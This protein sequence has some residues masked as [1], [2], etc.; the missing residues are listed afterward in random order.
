M[1]LLAMQLME[2][3]LNLALKNALWIASGRRGLHGQ[4]APTRVLQ[5][6]GLV[7]EKEQGQA[8]LIHQPIM[9]LFATQLM[10]QELNLAV[11]NALST[12]TGKPGTIGLIVRRKIQG[13][14]AGQATVRQ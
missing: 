12:V 9:E 11:K 5:R 3:E 13:P 6:M 4:A 14:V 2:V 10:E 8:K 7:T 1:E